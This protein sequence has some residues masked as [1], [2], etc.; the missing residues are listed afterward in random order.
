MSVLAVQ[1]KNVTVPH[2]GVRWFVVESKDVATDGTNWGWLD[3]PDRKVMWGTPAFT[4]RDAEELCNIH[5]NWL[6]S[7]A[8]LVVKLQEAKSE[9]LEAQRVYNELVVKM[10]EVS[11]RLNEARRKV[12]DLT[13]AS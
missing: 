9:E 1:V 8:S 2:N 5:N 7:K 12:R 6:D 11:N 4:A 10:N 3:G 13:V